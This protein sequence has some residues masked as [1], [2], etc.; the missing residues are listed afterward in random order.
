MFSKILHYKN[1]LAVRTEPIGL[2]ADN[3]LIYPEDQIDP[4]GQDQDQE[5][6]QHDLNDHGYNENSNPRHTPEG[7]VQ[8]ANIDP[9]QLTTAVAAAVGT[10]QPP[11]GY[12]P[13]P[14]SWEAPV[15]VASKPK[16]LYRFLK[17]YEELC[18]QCRIT[19]SREKIDNISQ[20][21][22]T[23]TESEWQAFVSY[24][25]GT[26]AEF[27]DELINSYPEAA[28]HEDGSVDKLE[29][30][31]KNNMQI[32]IRD[33]S[34]LM[35]LKRGFMAEVAK[36]T[37]A[38]PPIISNQSL[39]RLFVGC[40]DKN[41]RDSLNQRLQIQNVNPVATGRRRDD[42][43]DLDFVI[44]MALEMTN[45]AINQNIGRQLYP[46]P[47]DAGKIP[48]DLTP[49][50]AEIDSLRNDVSGMEGFIAIGVQRQTE[51]YNQIMGALQKEMQATIPVEWDLMEMENSSANYFDS[52]F[53]HGDG[54][55]DT[56]YKY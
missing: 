43:Y 20:Y 38:N 10:A 55:Y 36:L 54:D 37:K 13:M 40:L 41:F 4:E 9:V 48:Q 29:I 53:V 42:L 30:I 15:F 22:D 21:A 3:H 25:N 31:C 33:Q 19:S 8:F 34:A 49:I 16:D 2:M 6:E 39:V 52:L 45:G 12:L 51:E 28:N 17:K 46:T 32:G 18:R 7:L 1:E 23:Q 56:D 11:R 14:G 5:D 50:Q 47:L 35:Q 24:E 44:K 26:W 27:K